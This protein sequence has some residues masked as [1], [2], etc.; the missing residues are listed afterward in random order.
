MRL[1]IALVI[2]LAAVPAPAQRAPITKLLDKVP[3]LLGSGSK[4]PSITMP[5]TPVIVGLTKAADRTVATDAATYDLGGFRLG[6]SE[7][8]AEAV[9]KGRGLTTK[10]VTRY[11]DFETQVRSAS[12]LTKIRS[13]IRK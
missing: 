2:G 7:A 10:A 11:V 13:A 9:A 5:A 1:T 12:A 6:M 4:Q 3:S 8:E